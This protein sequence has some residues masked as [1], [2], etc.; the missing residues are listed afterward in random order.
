MKGIIENFPFSKRSLE[1]QLMQRFYREFHLF[2]SLNSQAM[3]EEFES[4]FGGVFKS[5][6]DPSLKGSLQVTIRGEYIDRVNP[7]QVE[8]WS[9]AATSDSMSI[10]FPSSYFRSCLNDSFNLS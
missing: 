3:P 7:Q 5:L 8:D 4:D 6:L 10:S 9:L 1:I 2:T